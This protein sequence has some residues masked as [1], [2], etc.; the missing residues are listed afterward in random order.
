MWCT[1]PVT[2]KDISTIASPPREIVE[3]MLVDT[4][5]QIKASV[6]VLYAMPDVMDPIEN[7]KATYIV[8]RL[9]VKSAVELL[10]HHHDA[11]LNSRH[12]AT[13]QVMQRFL[14]LLEEDNLGPAKIDSLADERCV[15]FVRE[16]VRFMTAVHT[17]L[18][19]DTEAKERR[20]FLSEYIGDWIL[21]A[22][23]TVIEA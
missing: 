17:L 5:C 11:S 16:L 3:G 4:L 20:A 13:R 21:P 22:A 1:V 6:D 2:S 12:R 8:A 9:E 18:H 14:A 23:D 10:Q 19:V 15:R 7:L